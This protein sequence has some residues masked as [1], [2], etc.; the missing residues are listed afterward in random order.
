MGSWKKLERG[1]SVQ[2]KFTFAA[3]IKET[4]QPIA[5]NSQIPRVIQRWIEMRCGGGTWPGTCNLIDSKF[6]LDRLIQL[7]QPRN[8]YIYKIPI[9]CISRLGIPVIDS[10]LGGMMMLQFGCVFFSPLDRHV[11]PYYSP[12]NYICWGFPTHYYQFGIIAGSLFSKSTWHTRS[13][14]VWIGLGSW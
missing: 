2:L 11:S 10:S 14:L 13:R 3:W 7:P 1:F 9:S 6:E 5:I 8:F 4:K 12:I